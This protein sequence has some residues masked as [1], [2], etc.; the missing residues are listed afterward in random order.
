MT[1]STLDTAAD[2]IGGIV[3]D[4]DGIPEEVADTASVIARVVGDTSVSWAGD[5]S[6][7]LVATSCV[8]VA[9]RAIRREDHI[10]QTELTEQAP[11]SH[12][13]IRRNYVDIPGVFMEH[14]RPEDL[15]ELSGETV[16]VLCVFAD[17]ERAGIGMSNI[18]PWACKPGPMY[19]LAA[20]VESLSSHT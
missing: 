5:R 15:D 7:E 10:T 2:V 18:D 8:Y 4:V 9:D 13:T 12:P 17:A 3:E 16:A 11:G 20:S 14:A 6:A 1:S 19:D